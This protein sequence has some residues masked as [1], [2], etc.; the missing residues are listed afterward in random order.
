[1]QSYAGQEDI[2]CDQQ[3]HQLQ[4]HVQKEVRQVW[5]SCFKGVNEIEE[6]MLTDAFRKRSIVLLMVLLLISNPSTSRRK[7]MLSEKLALFTNSMKWESLA[8]I[9]MYASCTLSVHCI[10]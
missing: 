10:G 4:R 9:L 7:C 2:L 1:M 5:Y 6:D 8:S 3:Q